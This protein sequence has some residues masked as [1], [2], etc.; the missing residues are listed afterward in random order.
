MFDHSVDEKSQQKAQD[1]SWA[2]NEGL[3]HGE[4][5]PK[6]GRETGAADHGGST[7]S[8]GHGLSSEI[9]GVA[10]RRRKYLSNNGGGEDQPPYT[11]RE[12]AEG[13]DI[14]QA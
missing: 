8:K 3:S 5:S 6:N 9:M 4:L 11:K 12:R 7:G 13:V 2:D 1:R 14:L 10:E